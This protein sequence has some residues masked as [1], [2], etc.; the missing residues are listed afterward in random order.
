MLGLAVV[1]VRRDVPESPRWLVMHG[2]VDEA[3]AVVDRI[4][5]AV[6]GPG[7]PPSRPEPVRVRVS[8]TVGFGHVAHWC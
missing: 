4:E 6:E 3:E 2:R 1:R 7:T 8:G 5:A